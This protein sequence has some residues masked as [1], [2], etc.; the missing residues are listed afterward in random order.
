MDLADAVPVLVGL[1]KLRLTFDG[2]PWWGEHIG[3]C[4]RDFQTSSTLLKASAVSRV[5]RTE[6][7]AAKCQ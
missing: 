6:H 2:T 3:L 1:D 7:Y 5:S 4:S